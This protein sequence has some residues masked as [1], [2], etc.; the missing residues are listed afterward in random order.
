MNSAV[1]THQPP[2]AKTVSSEQRAEPGFAAPEEERLHSISGNVLPCRLNLLGDWKE[3]TQKGNFDT[4]YGIRGV[5][6]IG[7]IAEETEMETAMV[8]KVSERWLRKVSSVEPIFSNGGTTQIDG[9]DWMTFQVAAVIDGL[10]VR[11][12]FSVYGGPEGTFQV[13]GST[14]SNLMEKYGDQLETAAK[15]F[16]FPKQPESAAKL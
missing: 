14:T 11:Y 10:K 2:V 8:A 4:F 5:A 16:T 15:S 9:R 6:F 7:V 13:I 1:E 12:I 3:F